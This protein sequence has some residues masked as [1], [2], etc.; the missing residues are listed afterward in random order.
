MTI[1]EEYA[2]FGLAPPEGNE[3]KFH[4]KLVIFIIGQGWEIYHP[5][6]KKT[7]G[8]KTA[9]ARVLT[10]AF[11]RLSLSTW[12]RTVDD[13]DA[14]AAGAGFA[15]AERGVIIFHLGTT[16]DPA[17]VWSW[18]ER[19]GWGPLNTSEPLRC[20]IRRR[21]GLSDDEDDGRGVG[22]AF[23]LE[24][25]WDPAKVWSWEEREGWGPLNTSTG[26]KGG[27]RNTRSGEG[28]SGGNYKAIQYIPR[29]VN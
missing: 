5:K 4:I 10:V 12:Y 29:V 23:A 19:E 18:E 1:A 21:L 14:R 17:K 8:S 6:H 15:A 2:V 27:G 7:T 25:T 16:W 3:P 11:N 13:D 20:R 28:G 24:T 9:W 26:K 22:A